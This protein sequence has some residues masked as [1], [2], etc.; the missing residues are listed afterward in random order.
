MLPWTHVLTAVAI[1]SCLHKASP[2]HGSGMDTHSSN[3]ATPVERHPPLAG[4]ANPELLP[5]EA[6]VL[7][8]RLRVAQFQIAQSHVCWEYGP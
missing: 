5:A 8:Q 2:A 1:W 3:P 6:A 4:L 7:S